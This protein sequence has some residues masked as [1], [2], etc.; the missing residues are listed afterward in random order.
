MSKFGFFIGD[1]DSPNLQRLLK[2]IGWMLSNRFELDLLVSDYSRLDKSA[3]KYYNITEQPPDNRSFITKIRQIRQYITSANPEV[4][5]QLTQPPNHGC[6]VGVACFNTNTSFVYRYSGDRFFNYNLRPGLQKVA[7]FGLNNII[8]RIPLRV[9]DQYIALGPTGK[10]RLTNRGVK[11]SDVTILPPAIA[12]ESLDRKDE[13]EINRN[14]PEDRK[15]ALFVGRRVPLKGLETLE[16]VIPEILKKRDDLQFVLVGGG[17]RSLSISKSF[18][19]HVTVVGKVP[20]SNVAK[21][22]HRANLLIH[23]SLTEGVP[24]TVLEALFADIPVIARDVGDV[25]TITENTF[26]EEAEFID[27]VCKFGELTVD[28]P[29]DFTRGKL[30]DRYMSFYN[31]L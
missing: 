20:P 13:T 23:P 2:N 30:K 18:Q 4:I 17:N 9:A 22:Y 27:M 11:E 28:D 10:Q 19:D 14:I 3:I 29:K 8:G 6:I 12:P 7:A 25:A 1:A 5:T 24:R 31:Q 15:I 21:Y 26:T 16:A